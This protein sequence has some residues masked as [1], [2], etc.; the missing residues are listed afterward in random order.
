MSKRIARKMFD[1]WGFLGSSRIAVIIS[2]EVLVGIFLSFFSFFLFLKIGQEVFE[3]DLVNF[4]KSVSLFFYTIRN[5]VLTKIMETITFF[6]SGLFL[7]TSA[8]VIIIYLYIKNHRKESF[9]FFIVLAMGFALNNMIKILV[10]RPR[11][12]ISPLATESTYS[13]P[14]GHTMSS[15]IFYALIAYFIFHFTKD[16]KLA[17]LVSG[18]SILIIILIGISRIY[19]G[20]HFPSD[21]IAGFIAGFWVFVTALLIRQTITFYKLFKETRFR[22]I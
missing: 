8:V 11:P 1:L 17:T 15:F 18:I 5:P 22:E 6:G 14:S 2:T 3:K 16:K 9:L 21:V 7:T 12:D 4:D 20:V 13:F 19:L 10:K